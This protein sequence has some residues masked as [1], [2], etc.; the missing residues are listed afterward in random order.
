L[1]LQELT[2]IQE[3]V[4]E[5]K[6]EQVMAQPVIAVT[7]ET[8]LSE[9]KEVLRANRISGVP[10][11]DAHKLVGIISIEDLIRALESQT[12]DGLVGDKMTRRVITVCCSESVIEAVELFALHQVGRLPVVDMKGNLVGM[13]TS[14]DITQGLL[15]AIGLNYHEEEISKY[16]AS[17]IFA[18]IVSDRTTLIL[19]YRVKSE[20]LSCGGE[21]ASHIKKALYRL[22]GSPAIIRR[23]A[24]ATYEAEMNLV[25][26]TDSGGDIIAEIQPG[27]IRILVLDNGPGIPDIELAMQPGY[28]TAPDWIRELGFGAGM[29]LVN[30]QRCADRMSL[31]SEPGIGTRLEME[32][33]IPEGEF[34]N[35]NESVF[36]KLKGSHLAEV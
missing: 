7:P 23:V 10:V 35:Q 18:D 36:D 17:H 21:A 2:K 12:V 14:S 25:I 3:L 28:S 8:S 34:H 27:K 30:I 16:R 24:I 1:E 11:L 29:G 33:D 4:Y 13:L 6:I 31:Q 20:N 32:I 22:G 15:E 5:L 19:S 9:L 26:H